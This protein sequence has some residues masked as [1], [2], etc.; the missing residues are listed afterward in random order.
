M[1]TRSSDPGS[2][3]QA[4][5]ICVPS[6]PLAAARSAIKINK[7]IKARMC[8]FKSTAGAANTAFSWVVQVQ[9]NQSPDFSSWGSVFD[10]MRVLES[11]LLFKAFYTAS[12]TALPATSPNAVVRYEP[13]Y[14]GNGLTSVHQGVESEHY[15]LLNVAFDGGHGCAPRPYSRT[16][17]QTLKVKCPTSGPSGP[18]LSLASTTLSTGVWRP[19]ND[20]NN[21]YWGAYNGYT[22]AG[23]TSAIIQMEAFCVMVV[24][25][26]SRR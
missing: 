24:E 10:E 11:S 5:F 26:R 18:D 20:A 1:K 9:P 25:F 15:Q 6:R 21:F 2:D 14:I 13:A 7:P 3:S 19:V 23:G 12:P 8:Y 4:N 16:G 22:A 17:F